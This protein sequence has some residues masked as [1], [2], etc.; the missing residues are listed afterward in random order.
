MLQCATG[1]SVLRLSKTRLSGGEE[2]VKVQKIYTEEQH[3]ESLLQ[4]LQN[5]WKQTSKLPQFLQVGKIL[6][7]HMLYCF[8]CVLKY[9]FNNTSKNFQT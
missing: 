1:E 9:F 7:Y 6:Y 5:E 3:H 8:I 2:A 4:F